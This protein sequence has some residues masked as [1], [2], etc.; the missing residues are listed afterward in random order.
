MSE[1]RYVLLRKHDV[2]TINAHLD[3]DLYGHPDWRPIDL[4]H[5]SVEVWPDSG[6]QDGASED[7]RVVD[8]VSLNSYDPDREQLHLVVVLDG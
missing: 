3:G 4:E 5:I 6:P 7:G 1:D 8:M 2:D